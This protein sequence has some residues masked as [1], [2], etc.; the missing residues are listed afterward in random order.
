MNLESI[1]SNLDKARTELLDL[2]LRN[3]LI[4]YRT[5]R[6]RGVET[7]DAVPTEVFDT[8]VRRSQNLYFLPHMDPDGSESS[9]A[10]RS[11]SRLQTEYDREELQRRL[12]NTSRISGTLIQ[13][14]GVNTLFI[15][16]G[17]VT[18]YESDSS[19][20]ARRAPLMLIPVRL[21]RT[22]VNASFR[23]NYTGDE[24]GA[25]LS[26]IQKARTEFGVN[27]PG[28]HDAD[29][30]DD[31]EIDVDE[32]FQRVASSMSDLER[33]S[34]D[35]SSVVL[36]FFSFNK[37][38]M[39][40]DLDADN[41]PPGM[42]PMSSPILRSLFGHE[43]FTER[44]PAIGDEDHLD[45]HLHPQD[46]HHVVDADSSQ[47]LAILD[48]SNGRNLVIQGPPGTG[49]S[50]TIA[51][52]IADAV[53]GHKTV[54]FVSE[55]MAALEVVKRRLDEIH[56]GDACLE[57]HSHKTNKRVVLDELKRTQGLGSPDTEGIEDDFA[58]LTRSRDWLNQLA[59]AVNY[60][61]G[62]TGISPFR[63]YGE[64]LQIRER[65]RDQLVGTFPRHPIPNIDSWSANAYD[66]KLNIVSNIQNSLR[67][68]GVLRD[69]PFWGSQVR[70]VLPPDVARLEEA[71]DAAVLTLKSV[72]DA[73][74]KLADTMGIDRPDSI[75][76]L[77]R[78]VAAAE[79]I[80]NAPDFRGANLD[81]PYWKDRRDELERLAYSGLRRVSLHEEYDSIIIPTAW[82]DD[83]VWNVRR[84]LTT[85]GRKF[86]RFL[87]P[88]YRHAKKRLFTLCRDGLPGTLEQ[89]IA[90]CEAV[91]ESQ[92]LSESIE[93]M[94]PTANAVLG[95]LWQGSGTD[96]EQVGE[97]ISWSLGLYEDIQ[98]DRIDAEVVHSFV[99]GLDTDHTSNQ[100]QR[101]LESLAEHLGRCRTIQATIEMDVEE[102][103][104]KTDGLYGI[105]F[106]EQNHLLMNWS[107]RAGEIQDIASLNIALDAAREEGLGQIAKLVEEWP[108]AHRHMRLCF[109]H[110]RYESIVS[111]AFTERPILSGFDGL[112]HE[113]RINSFREMDKLALD[114]NRSRV[115]YAHWQKLPGK[116]RVRDNSES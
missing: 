103:F 2:G 113:D 83:D 12:L 7:V 96:W 26:F 78:L 1:R 31:E 3:P 55:K 4:N 19:Q 33:W 77:R 22:S 25:N 101:T 99:K 17:M 90:L 44:E 72:M 87:Y 82:N 54:L 110:L 57:L 95:T 105:P 115:A 75:S 70:V 85:T 18:W 76:D 14:Q 6:V 112:G 88:E 15:A 116:E 98:N 109:E 28:L 104:G 61:I 42:G 66:E 86:F 100:L 97:V 20:D 35:F 43:G 51:N 93:S 30:E 46:M 114:H 89:Q 40:R 68:I 45:E 60:P 36:G 53:S 80:V 48:V 5:L 65:M 50:Q 13:E 64:H 111:R 8:L 106:E 102:R 41:W 69:H 27:L 58:S 47:A 24:L 59:E 107:Q 32:Y 81:S 84:S 74:R 39:Y 34:V 94:E 38:L 9:Q 11:R 52:I 49:K 92:Q 73:S 71:A 21:E 16:L 67:N 62:E 63:A 10:K 23:V 108:D 56:L 29:D 91:I 37:L 79:S